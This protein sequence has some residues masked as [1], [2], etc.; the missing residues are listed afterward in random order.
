MKE[1][2]LVTVDGWLD[3]CGVKFFCAGIFDNVE[4]AEMVAKKY[5]RSKIIKLEPN[6]EYPLT[7]NDEGWWP[8]LENDLCIGDYIE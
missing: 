8:V 4:A 3:C 1:I 7:E 2:Y 6:K 5:E